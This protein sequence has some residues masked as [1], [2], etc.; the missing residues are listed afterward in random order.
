MTLATHAIVGA[1]VAQ[2]FPSN[3]LLAFM[4]GFAS[5]YLTDAIPHW[6]YKILSYRRDPKDPMKN[7][8]EMRDP[9]FI[10]DLLRIMC[11]LFFGVALS[12]YLFP[13]HNFA[14]L[15]TLTG[16][17]GGIFPDVLQLA[18][19]KIR[20]EPLISLQRFHNLVHTDIRL[21]DATTGIAFQTI[22]I[23]IVFFLL[24]IFSRGQI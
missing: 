14:P 9:N 11:D 7:D 16:V 20:R 12:L 2:F 22:L 23:M 4:A 6:D 17:I 10:Y 13:I 3:P 8:I 15:I 24:R 21:Q 5:H 18:Y 1:T 19:L